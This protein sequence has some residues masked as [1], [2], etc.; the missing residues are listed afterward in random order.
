MKLLSIPAV[1]WAA[2]RALLLKERLKT[3]VAL[4]PLSERYREDPY[5]KVRELREKDPVHWMELTGA[6]WLGRYADIIDV[7]HDPSFSARRDEPAGGLMDAE[8]I[9][10]S[11]FMAFMQTNLLGIDRP[12]HTRLRAL[13]NKAFTP[14]V[15]EEIRP[16]VQQITDELLDSA[17][18]RSA[19]NGRQIEVMADLAKPLPVIVIAELLG[20]PPEDRGRL[21]RW[22]YDLARALDPIF[23]LEVLERADRA[24]VEL[25][26]YFRPLLEERR[27]APRDDMLTALVQAE[28]EGETLDEEELYSFCILLLGAGSETTTNLIG[29]GLLAL[30]RNR[31]QLE[32]LRDDPS[33]AERAVEELLRYDSPVAMTSRIATEETEIGGKRVRAGDFLVLSIA[34]ANRDPEQFPDPDRLD[35]GREENRH[36]S[37]SLGNHYCLGAP[38]ARLEGRIALTALIER[39][40]N[41]RLATARQQWRETVTLRGLSAL[42]VAY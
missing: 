10:A 5:P 2:I 40:P 23:E 11:E 33:I 38:L 4:N 6:W 28:E 13:V 34:G 8:A 36:L 12:D 25:R 31:D 19:Q 42:P 24:V 18:A 14:R 16:R 22:S 20:V 9:M 26:Q 35:I 17:E 3:G 30:L 37:F 39:F 41:L 15:V 21:R 7:L 32:R 27:R 1:R 29:N